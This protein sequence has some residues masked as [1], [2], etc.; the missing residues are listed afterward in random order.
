MDFSYSE[1]QEA[2]REL[3]RKILSDHTT[4]ERLVEIEASEDGIDHELWRELARA[5]LVG[6]CLPQAHG[7][8][9]LGMWNTPRA[10]GPRQATRISHE[11]PLR[12]ARLLAFLGLVAREVVLGVEVVQRDREHRG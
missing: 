12:R 6:A 5:N 10:R 11:L 4:H 9:D 1:D 2:L 8:M 3:A 7:G